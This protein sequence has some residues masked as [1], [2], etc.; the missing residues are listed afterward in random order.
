VNA[1][2]AVSMA[3]ATATNAPAPADTTPPTIGFTS[4]ANGDTISGTIT[5]Q[6]N[7]TDNV[8]VASVSLAV[9]GSGIGTDTTAPYT[10]SVNTS[11]LINGSH[12]LSATAKDAAGNASSASIAVT[13]N[14]PVVSGNPVVKITSPQDG[15]TLSKNVVISATVTDTVAVTLTQL[16]IDGNLV[17]TSTTSSISMHWS[18]RSVAPGSHTISA[19]ARDISG[20]VAPVNTITVYT[21]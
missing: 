17:A 9:D 21:K 20:A 2:A 4:P 16:Y 14:N 18:T 15:A 13:V 1:A 11:N 10:F 6:V 8:G 12:T 19:T 7:A 5:S 3:L